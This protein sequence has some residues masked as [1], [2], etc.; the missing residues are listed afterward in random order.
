LQI[1]SEVVMRK[2]ARRPTTP[3][4]PEA[5]LERPGTNSPGS[6][7][8]S[9]F[10]FATIP[11]FPPHQS[12][13]GL[14]PALRARMEHA[15][16]SDFS[17]LRIYED[18]S[19]SRI[20]ARAYTDGNDLHF[21]PGRFDP[22]S[23]DGL[24][25]LGHELTH[26][27][28][29][30][31]GNVRPSLYGG[32]VGD[33]DAVPLQHPRLPDSFFNLDSGLEREADALGQRA[34]RGEQVSVP[35]S[36]SPAPVSGVIQAS[37]E[38]EA[39]LNADL[40]SR[41]NA[42][43]QS[44]GS[45]QNQDLS[46]QNADWSTAQAQQKADIE[47]RANLEYHKRFTADPVT[48]DVSAPVPSHEKMIEDYQKAEQGFQRELR[49]RERAANPTN[50][51]GT[52][53]TTSGDFENTSSGPGQPIAPATMTPIGGRV[54][55]PKNPGKISDARKN[56]LQAQLDHSGRTN[57]TLPT[58]KIAPI[59]SSLKSSNPIDYQTNLGLLGKKRPSGIQENI[60]ETH[61]STYL[62]DHSD[63]AKFPG[64]HAPLGHAHSAHGFHIPA[65]EQIERQL[66]GI[67]PDERGEGSDAFLKTSNTASGTVNLPNGMSKLAGK[68]KN[69]TEQAEFNAI[70]SVSS[71][72][73]I[74][75]AQAANNP[76]FNPGLPNGPGNQPTLSGQSLK[77]RKG[78]LG[79]EVGTGGTASGFTSALAEYN[80]LNHNF[81]QAWQSK[82]HPDFTPGQNVAVT[83]Q[84]IGNPLGS[85]H[86]NAATW[87]PEEYG[88]GFKFD[89]TANPPK[90][91]R[92][93]GDP[94]RAANTVSRAEAITVERQNSSKTV[95]KKLM[96][97]KT[98][99][100]VNVN[101]MNGF[102]VTTNF[103]N[104]DSQ[105]IN[106]KATSTAPASTGAVTGTVNI[107]SP[108]Q[109]QQTNARDEEKDLA[110]SFAQIDKTTTGNIPYWRDIF[111]D[112][113][114]NADGRMQPEL[115][116]DGK[117]VK[118]RF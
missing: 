110:D 5:S 44:H 67:R 30:R 105:G 41:A 84:N 94:T 38:D 104:N 20:H 21:A 75:A 8:F 93:D 23:P 74:T 4:A 11:V 37:P 99:N 85:T 62:D 47:R 83:S 66:Y 7:G 57:S 76:N 82:V 60:V 9:G 33:L 91:N 79:F 49:N 65:V 18:D 27:V 19:A 72:P 106:R 117:P 12:G 53:L 71:F 32:P 112:P 96:D 108:F 35:S 114:L 92:S 78:D 70:T 68:G 87:T 2:A 34:A 13:A 102:D 45:P 58:P 3:F 48:H 88:R 24:A 26:V 73:Q 109:P 64:G 36:P 43:W 52:A 16:Q 81:A 55:D 118:S 17:A 116:K 39:R 113:V 59:D 14:A 54:P 111:G 103:P 100:G 97:N 90:L 98:I 50:T 10:D 46:A 22:N 101:L 6:S 29:Q 40:E 61:L 42:V 63:D 95:V 25:L 115:G 28:Q 1:E 15:F 51:A 107:G 56:L 77:H 89:S 80:S 69:L 86:P 31:Q